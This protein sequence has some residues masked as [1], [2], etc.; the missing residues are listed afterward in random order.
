MT[1]LEE[2]TPAEVLLLT[3]GSRARL[4]PALE[5]TLAHL[6]Q[7]RVLRIERE[8]NGE[9]SYLRRGD[10]FASA[11]TLRHEEVFLGPLRAR[12]EVRTLLAN[13]V[14][15]AFERAR[16]AKHFFRLVGHS[17]RLA[18]CFRKGFL[19]LFLA[20]PGRRSARGNELASALQRELDAVE[21]ALAEPVDAPQLSQMI[22]RYAGHLALCGAAALLWQGAADDALF[23]RAERRMAPDTSSGSCS[24]A[25]SSCGGD[26]GDE[27][28]Q[29]FDAAA[30]AAE[31]SSDSGSSGC[32][33]EGGSSG[34]SGCGGGD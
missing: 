9:A 8:A 11:R 25:G 3:D 6:L 13:A 18:G 4:R 29:E 17:P 34:C 15:V 12:P 30:D 23:A 14:Q 21:R 5:A 33:G 1:L 22:E 28:R 32:S 7:R 26:G 24:G 31:A 2:W 20:Y 27:L 16:S 19:D 10:A